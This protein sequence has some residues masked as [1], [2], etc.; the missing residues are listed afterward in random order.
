MTLTFHSI[1][2]VHHIDIGVKRQTKVGGHLRTYLLD[3]NSFF[4]GRT[5]H[6]LVDDINTG[7]E[8]FHNQLSESLY[9]CCV[10]GRCASSD[11]ITHCNV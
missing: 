7:A 1:F 2:F 6:D 3:W 4:L 9:E 8:A 10:H 11:I 5:F